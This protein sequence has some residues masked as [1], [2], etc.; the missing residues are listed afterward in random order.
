LVICV[1]AGA[2]EVSQKAAGSGRQD[3]GSRCRRLALFGD[4]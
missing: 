2:H 1:T 4:S 3:P